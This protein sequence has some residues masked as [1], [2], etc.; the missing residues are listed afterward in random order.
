MHQK[1]VNAHDEFNNWY[2][3]NWRNK[4]KT[5]PLI[6]KGQKITNKVYMNIIMEEGIVINDEGLNNG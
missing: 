3:K 6:K 4:K 1:V 2:Y 5:P